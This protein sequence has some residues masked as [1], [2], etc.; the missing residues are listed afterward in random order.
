MQGDFIQGYF[1]EGEVSRVGVKYAIYHVVVTVPVQHYH[2]VNRALYRVLCQVLCFIYWSC[3]IPISSAS[4]LV[5][6]DTFT[7]EPETTL[8]CDRRYVRASRT[9]KRFLGA[10]GLL[11]ERCVV[12][13]TSSVRCQTQAPW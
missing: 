12:P 8:T 2:G 7:K 1:R 4:A 13:G 5:I 11:V 3:L 10:V 9:I 6:L